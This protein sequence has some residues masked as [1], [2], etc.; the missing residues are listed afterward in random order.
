MDGHAER[1]ESWRPAESAKAHTVHSD[2]RVFAL[3]DTDDLLDAV[4]RSLWSSGFLAAEISVASGRTAAERFE[5][6]LD[7]GQYLVS[8]V[9]PSDARRE[10]AAQLLAS[11]GGRMI[12]L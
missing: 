5:Q 12:V 6:T 1:E 4:L 8:V 3:V 7:D 2:H 9:V 10:L 11:H